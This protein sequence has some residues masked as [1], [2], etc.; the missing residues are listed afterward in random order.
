MAV[1]EVYDALGPFG[2][3]AQPGQVAQVAADD[4]G[5]EI[6][7]L[8]GG[9]VGSR[10]PEH[11]VPGGDEFG[12]AGRTDPARRT[13]HEQS[14]E[15]PPGILVIA[16]DDFGVTQDLSRQARVMMSST[17]SLLASA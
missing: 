1:A 2:C 3:G 13:G 10:Q 4:L 14:H 15:M 16:F 7:D 5:A 12:H 8:G 9:L 6:L 17:T 11:V